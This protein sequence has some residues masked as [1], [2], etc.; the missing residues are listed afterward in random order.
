M[1]KHYE[2]SF[3]ADRT[4]N[5]SKRKKSGQHRLRKKAKMEFSMSSE[6]MK[7]EPKYVNR[8]CRPPKW[9]IP[10]AMP[11]PLTSFL[12]PLN[13]MPMKPNLPHQ[14]SMLADLPAATLMQK[15]PPNRL[16]MFEL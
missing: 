7:K 13:M 11:N 14:N 3:L 4:P 15:S 5:A 6:E 9:T 2:N 1:F 8:A 12:P 10:V 16:D